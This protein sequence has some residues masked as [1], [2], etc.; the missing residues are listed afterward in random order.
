MRIKNIIGGV[1]CVA[2]LGACDMD[3]HEYAHYGKD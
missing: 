3:Y 2:L 1:A